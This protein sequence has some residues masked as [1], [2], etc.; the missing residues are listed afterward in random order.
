MLYFQCVVARLASKEASRG[1]FVKSADYSTGMVVFRSTNASVEIGKD[2]GLWVFWDMTEDTRDKVVATA[3]SLV[4][5]WDITGGGTM[6]IFKKSHS[7][8]TITVQGFT[9][10]MY[11]KETTNRANN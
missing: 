9:L 5:P 1:E 2:G 10:A 8:L 7:Q 6:R 4:G 3:P 11:E